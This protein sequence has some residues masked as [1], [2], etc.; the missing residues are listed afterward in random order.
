MEECVNPLWKHRDNKIKEFEQAVANNPVEYL[1]EINRQAR[2][3]VQGK[4][5]KTKDY[6]KMQK[7][8][9]EEDNN[10]KQD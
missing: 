5:L 1:K 3:L 6:I 8:Q 9:L 10:G 2:I 7:E 4:K